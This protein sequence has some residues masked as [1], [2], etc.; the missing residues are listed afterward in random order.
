MYKNLK[1]LS[2]KLGRSF[3]IFRGH[4][5]IVETEGESYHGNDG[6]GDW[7]GRGEDEEKLGIVTANGNDRDER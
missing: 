3:P 6:L 2:R 4:E 7:P 5:R 1:Y